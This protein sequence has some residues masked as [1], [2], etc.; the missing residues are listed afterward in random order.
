[1]R[2]ASTTSNSPMV[3]ISPTGTMSAP[4]TQY[5]G[6]AGHLR[7]ELVAAVVALGA[8]VVAF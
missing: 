1:M 8:F 6:G 7:Q 5:T 3:S 4:V 2:T